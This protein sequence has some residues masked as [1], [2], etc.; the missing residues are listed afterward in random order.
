[1]QPT[2][3]LPFEYPNFRKY[4]FCICVSGR[5]HFSSLAGLRWSTD[6]V[7]SDWNCNKYNTSNFLANYHKLF[8]SRLLHS[9]PRS[10]GLLTLC[11]MGRHQRP[12]T[13][14]SC[15]VVHTFRNFV[16]NIGGKKPFFL[17]KISLHFFSLDWVKQSILPAELPV[18]DGPLP[19]GRAAAGK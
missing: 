13:T 14:R 3:N 12:C 17:L 7:S 8:K 16:L 15:C 2:A 18:Q 9:Q 6:P 10:S 4:G 5:V 11:R 1:M 19:L